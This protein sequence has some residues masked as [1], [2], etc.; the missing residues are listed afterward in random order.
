MPSTALVLVA[1]ND[2]SAHV[3]EIAPRLFLGNAA[4]ASSRDCLAKC[5]ITHVVTAAQTDGFGALF[6]ESFT[7]HVL[8]VE[9][10][11]DAPIADLLPGSAEFIDG[12][13]RESG[14]ACAGGAEASSG[15]VL[16]HCKMGT[17]RSAAVVIHYLMTKRAF[18][19]RGALL[20]IMRVRSASPR[21]PY[22]HPNIG[23]LREL[24]R[25][26]AALR[27]PR[28]VSLTLEDYVRDF[29]TGKNLAEEPGHCAP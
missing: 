3:D 8:P 19:L 27:G 21:A 13:L 11:R 17:S 25:V 10:S 4:F 16:V 18:T 29:S 23:F 5:G 12:V 22:T 15:A 14:S 24:I 2:E 20:H 6:P 9:D 26:E 7:Y 28:A 1:A